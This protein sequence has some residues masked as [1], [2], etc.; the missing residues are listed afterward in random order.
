MRAPK[1]SLY[2]QH[3]ISVIGV[4][5]VVVCGYG[6]FL[7]HT[8]MQPSAS[9]SSS[10]HVPFVKN[11]QIAWPANVNAAVG[12]ATDG[13]LAQSSTHE[14][15]HSTASM[16]KVIT[17]LAVLQRQPLD[18]DQSGPTYTLTAHDVAIYRQYVQQDGSVLPVY[19]G[20]QL[21]EYQMLQAMLI[22][23]ADNIADT[24]AERVF[25]S[26]DAYVAYAQAMVQSMGLGQTTIAD[27]SGYDPNTVSTPSNLVT[28]GIAA[29]NNPVI[30]QIV[31]Q[32]A[33]R[34]PG[35]GTIKNTNQLLGTD[36]VVGI[37][38]G[39]TDSAGKCLLFASQ[40]YSTKNNKQ[41][42]IV[43]VIMS[44]SNEANLVNDSATL[45]HSA[46]Q[47]IDQNNS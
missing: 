25:G 36:G 27:A 13:V 47:G 38:T 32:P 12:T 39:T 4:I 10:L 43:G 30:A 7:L 28:V 34:I 9:H 24:L 2:R 22:A 31:A 46:E 19:Q 16:A 14:T 11:L 40:Y 37:K 29:I 18:T 17:A 42:T 8:A 33:A 1:Q 5:A 6:I 23:S 35:V 41:T 20:M 3:V 26:Q 45:L 21:T 44:D 15:P